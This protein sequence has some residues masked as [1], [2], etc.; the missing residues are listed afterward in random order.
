MRPRTFDP[1][2]ARTVEWYWARLY[3]TT[4]A[5]IQL[6]APMKAR[7]IEIALLLHVGEE[8][9][10]SVSDMHEGIAHP[11]IDPA[12]PPHDTWYWKQISAAKTYF[13][14]IR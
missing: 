11:I 5:H 13:Y 7:D 6:Q 3:L 2:K 4:I 9:A 8:R 1:A 14:Y 10:R 12:R